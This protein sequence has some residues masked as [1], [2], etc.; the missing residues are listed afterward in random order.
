MDYYND[1]EKPKEDY[2]VEIKNINS[3]CSRYEIYLAP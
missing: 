3:F 1:I 2:N